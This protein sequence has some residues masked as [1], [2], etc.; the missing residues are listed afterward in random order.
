[1]GKQKRKKRAEK[2]GYCSFGE[3]SNLSRGKTAKFQ[4]QFWAGF[5]WKSF[6]EWKRSSTCSWRKRRI[7]RERCWQFIWCCLDEVGGSSIPRRSEFSVSF[8]TIAPLLVCRWNN[9]VT[10]VISSVSHF[11]A[12]SQGPNLR[13][14]S[15][16]H[17]I[18]CA[19]KWSFIYF[20]WY[21]GERERSKEEQQFT[22]PGC[23]DPNC[24]CILE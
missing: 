21:V 7:W 14:F 24:P 23:G 1:M 20:P 11:I 6:M 8:A 17:P 3:T 9:Y 22:H 2:L 10:S 15:S 13:H 12:A 4:I 5:M 18:P 16:G 19:V